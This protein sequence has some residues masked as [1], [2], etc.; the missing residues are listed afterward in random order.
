MNKETVIYK[1]PINGFCEEMEVVSKDENGYYVKQ[2]GNEE[3][4][5]GV[6]ILKSHTKE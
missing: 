4:V 5:K 2:F 3:D 6:Y 1:S